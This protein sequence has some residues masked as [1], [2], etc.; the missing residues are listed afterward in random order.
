M[1]SVSFS[2]LPV[3][4]AVTS[5]NISHSFEKWSGF[6]HSIG[7]V[8]DPFPIQI[9]EY[10][11]RNSYQFI[12]EYVL[13]KLVHA[14]FALLNAFS[15]SYSHGSHYWEASCDLPFRSFLASPYAFLPIHW[16][17][18]TYSNCI[19]QLLGLHLASIH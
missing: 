12:N 6:L 18:I 17:S 13:F 11:C 14:L 8:P 4:T 1:I 10:I 3:T 5:T 2:T 7:S 16:H 19:L 9:H 15:K